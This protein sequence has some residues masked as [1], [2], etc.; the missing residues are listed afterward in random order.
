[1]PAN[2][3][4]EYPTLEMAATFLSAKL[5]ITRQGTRPETGSSEYEELAL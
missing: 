5:V 4:F 1:L 3:F 2:F